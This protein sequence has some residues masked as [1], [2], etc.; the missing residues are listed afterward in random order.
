MIVLAIDIDIGG[1]AITRASW[2]GGPRTV[3]LKD[4]P[5]NETG[6]ITSIEIYVKSADIIDVK[7][8]TFFVVSGNNLS[9]RDTHTIGTVISDSKQTFSGLSIDVEAGD[10]IGIYYKGSGNL[11]R[12]TS[13]YAGFWNYN[14]DQIPCTDVTFTYYANQIFSLYGTGTTGE[15]EEDNVIFFGI[16]F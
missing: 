1:A 4:N 6:T 13:G 7:V 9:T 15:E 2:L 5:A 16:N 14:S 12:D 10:Y 11:Y 3:V 8:A